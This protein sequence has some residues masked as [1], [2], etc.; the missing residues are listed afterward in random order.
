MSLLSE[1][2]I[3]G[4]SGKIF[5]TNASRERD[6]KRIK[7]VIMSVPGVD[8][9]LIV[10]EVFPKEFIVRTDKLVA[11]SAIENAVQLLGFHVIPKGIFSWQSQESK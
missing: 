6:L 5:A 11:I 10:K 3:P 9:V 8:D 7:K 4:E 1:H 2:V